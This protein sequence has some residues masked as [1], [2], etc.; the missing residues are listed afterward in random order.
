MN[1]STSDLRFPTNL[2]DFTSWAQAHGKLHAA[3]TSR[4]LANICPSTTDACWLWIG[5]INVYGY[6][7]IHTHGKSVLA[8]RILWILTHNGELAQNLQVCHSC[9]NK[10]CVNPSHLFLGTNEDNHRD[11]MQKGRQARGESIGAAK[12][13]TSEVM[14]IRDLTSY[15]FSSREL[16]SIYGV[17]NKTIWKAAHCVTWKGA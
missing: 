1:N 17:N 15:G 14:Q 8:H 6:G 2:P 9:D 5:T 7:Q 12:L 11:K 4:V 10:R 3:L 13:S 16:A